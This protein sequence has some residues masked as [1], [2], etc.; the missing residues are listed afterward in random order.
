MEKG[1]TSKEINVIKR[2]GSKTPLDL[3][4]VHRMVE[5]ACEG[6]AGVSESHVE[7]NSG[8]QFFDGIK[9]SDIQ[10]ILIRSANDLISLDAP[11]YQYVAARLLLFSLRKS[12]YGE[13]PDKHPHLRAHVDRCI[14]SGIYDAGIVNQYTLEEWDKLNSFIDH[15][16]DYLFTYAGIRQVADKYLVQDRSTGEIYETPQ[17]MYIMV[18]ATL[19]QDDDKFYRLDYVKKYYDAISKHRLNIPTPI[20]GGVRTPIRQFASCVLVDIDDTLDSI[21]SS[22]MAIGKY[23]AQRAGIGINAGRIRGINSKIRGGEVQHTGVVPFLKKF[24][25][26]VRCC[27]QNGIRGG[28]AT[29]H[30]PIWHQEI[31]DIL[32]LKNNKGTEDNRVRKLDYSI[33]LSKIFYARFIQDAEI[34]L[35]SPHDVPDLFDAFGTDKFDELYESYEKNKE[36]PKKT[37]GAQKLILDLLKE[38]AETGRLYIMNIDHCNDHSSFK[39]KVSMSNLCQEITLPTDPIQHIDG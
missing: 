13:H 7:V 15:D 6:L 39:D 35:F 34:T 30:F 27:T 28:S 26:T 20:M 29:V 21:F 17:F 37:V 3:D 14:A 19:F 18:A 12:V 8:L 11:N 25:S 10:E 38:R 2:D 24:E 4:K 33:Q 23:V 1:M 9:T 16:R 5:L 36:I 22:D 31:E 32:V